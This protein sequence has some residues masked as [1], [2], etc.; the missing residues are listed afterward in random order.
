MKKWDAE[1]YQESFSFVYQYGDDVLSWLD[2]SP[3]MRVLD[4]GC[5]NGILTAKMAEK[6]ALVTGIDSSLEMFALAKQAHASLT[7]IHM[8]ATQ[9]HFDDEFDAVF[10][11]AVFHWISDQHRLISGI[12][13]SLKKGGHL[14]CEFGGEG[15]ALE[16]HK[17][18]QS[19]F[20]KHGLVYRH[21]FYFPTIGMY[22]P[23][24]EEHGLKVTQ[25][26]LFPRPTK[27][28]AG[29]TVTDWINMF[30][31]QPFAGVSESVKKDILTQAEK[32]LMPVLYQ[33]NAWFIDY[34]R[35]RI[36]AVKQ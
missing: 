13:R 5:G 34:V 1:G 4:I 25:A 27:L 16:V 33:D 31:T 19:A 21:A 17:A 2:I 24:L 28:T 36:K 26:S 7:F 8:D 15:C 10:S 12:S 18:L 29:D 22:A 14:V 3:G 20:E 23:L 11:N 30:I 9:M 35:I 6:G 32:T